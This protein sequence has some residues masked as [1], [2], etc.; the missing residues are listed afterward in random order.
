M[1]R[2]VRK[3]NTGSNKSNDGNAIIALMKVMA[4]IK[5]MAVMKV[6]KVMTVVKYKK[7]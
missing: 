1:Y 5:V 2:S 7:R 4:V 6:M 3:E